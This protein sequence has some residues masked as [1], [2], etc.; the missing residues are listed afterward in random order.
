MIL[1]PEAR[2]GTIAIVGVLV[3]AMVVVYLGGL[4]VGPRGYEVKVRL[5]NA[6][7]LEEGA[8]VRMAGVKVGRV[9]SVALTYEPGEVASQALVTVRLNRGVQL[10]SSSIIEVAKGGLL[11][12]YYIE[13]TPIRRKQDRLVKPGAL[14]AG[15][16]EPQLEDLIPQADKLLTQLQGISTNLH[17]LTG[18]EKFLFT[19]KQ[20]VSDLGATA[21]AIRQM[22]TNPSVGKAITASALNVQMATAHAVLAARNVADATGELKR[23]RNLLANL[24]E[25]TAE[26]RDQIAGIMGN[27][28]TTT[29]NLKGISDTL[30]WLVAESGTKENVQ[31]TLAS[32]SVA[33]KNVEATSDSLRKLSGDEDL[34]RNLKAAVEKLRVS[35]ENVEATTNSLRKVSD[36]EA[37]QRDLKVSVEKL[38][39][40]L[41]NVATSTAA[42]KELLTD[43]QVQSDLRTTIHEASDTVKSVKK[44]VQ[45]VTKPLGALSDLEAT[46]DIATWYSPALNH[47]FTDF[48]LRLSRLGNSFL[49]LG[50]HDLGESE[51]LN[52]Q[53]GVLRPPFSYRFG[54]YRSEIGIGADYRLGQWGS[55]SFNLYDPNNLNFNLWSGWR[56]GDHLRL[57]LGVEDTNNRRVGGAGIQFTR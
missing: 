2:V 4:H 45:Q 34:Q 24:E 10:W 42:L 8:P 3:T 30:R 35:L 39:L 20:I 32:L 23:V 40:S 43:P 26:N 29:E 49:D 54:L 1:S 17:A 15:R 56:L 33:A 9:E 7:G 14:L 12:E 47:A 44:T 16:V 28:Q 6:R 19:I 48:N 57:M 11:G 5:A 46:P 36:D 21:A 22:V 53:G 41:E 13:I 50:I 18:D 51:R 37:L 25:I 52:L 55:L 27:L 38:R 31:Q